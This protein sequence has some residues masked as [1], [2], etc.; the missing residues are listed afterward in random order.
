MNFELIDT[1]VHLNYDNFKGKLP[2][3]RKRWQEAGIVHL[4]HS[5]VEPKEFPIIQAIADQ[6]PEISLSVGLHPLDV[7]KW[8]DHT[9]EEIL[10]LAQSDHRVVAL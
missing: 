2:E 8:T 9:C 6:I 5:C 1:H 3:V 10:I 7:E 4:I